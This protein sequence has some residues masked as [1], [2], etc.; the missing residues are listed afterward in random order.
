MTAS[1]V[2]DRDAD[3]AKRELARESLRLC[4][5]IRL[6][7]MG[8]S[9]LP[10]IWPGDTLTIES[11][12]WDDVSAGEIVLYERSR[13]FFIHRV[14]EKVG[15][16]ES[17]AVRTRGD[18]MPHADAPV[19]RQDVLGTVRIVSRN[20]K[21]FAPAKNLRLGDRLV[22]SLAGRWTLAAR[23]VVGLRWV[24]QAS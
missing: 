21:S 11:S 18:A 1:P 2:R 9:M 10:S 3:S 24:W 20:G 15:S 4:G 16:G 23:L 17:A 8:W 22:A 5:T 7:V 6:K 12:K 19:P 14:I 13:G